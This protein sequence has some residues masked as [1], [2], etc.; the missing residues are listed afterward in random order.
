MECG[1]RISK[2][3]VELGFTQAPLA[4][5]LNI[6][7]DYYRSIET[8]RRGGSIDIIVEIAAIFDVSL[9]Y[10]ILGRLKYSDSRRI[11]KEL[12]KI[13]GQLGELKASM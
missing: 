8:G 4:E 3:R 13:M 6:S 11:Q 5:K 7:L 1:L 10:L 12:E 2:L 9:D